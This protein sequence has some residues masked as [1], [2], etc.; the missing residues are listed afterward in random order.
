MTDRLER[1]SVRSV[2]F[3]CVENACRS[4]M[5]E[6]FARALAPSL[7]VASAGT[8]PAERVEPK[9]VEVMREVGIDI[10]CQRPKA[11]ADCDVAAY[12]Y[13]ITMGCGA[14]GVCPAGFLGVTEDW[15]IPDP[16][17]KS[18]EEFRRVRD[19]IREKVEELLARMEKE[20]G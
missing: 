1:E 9:A 18:L 11:L 13:V 8:R 19:L 2:L 15:D 14:A 6:G 17:G 5:A 3:V 7:R 12:D 10:S 4:Q 16:R 20:A